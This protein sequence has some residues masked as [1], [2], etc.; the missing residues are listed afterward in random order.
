[1]IARRLTTGHVEFGLRVVG[2]GDY[3]P[4]IRT[5]AADVGHDA[6]IRSDPIIIDLSAVELVEGEPTAVDDPSSAGQSTIDLIRERGA[7]RCGVKQTQPLFG[8]READGT[9]TGFDIE[10]CKALAAALEVELTLIDASH[11]SNPL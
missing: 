4:S 8:F 3:F 11:A 7:L 10:F 9:V 6:W 5:I 2:G 1:M